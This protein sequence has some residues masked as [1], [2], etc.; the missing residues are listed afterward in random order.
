LANDYIEAARV[1]HEVTKHSYTSVRSSPHLLDWELKPLPYKIYPGAASVTLPRDLNL[2]GTPTLTALTTQIGTQSSAPVDITALTRIV[3][4]ADGLTRRK[5]VGGEDYHFRAAP[6]AGALYPIEIYVSAGEVEGLETG[7]YHFSPADLRMT[8][9]RRGDWREYL[10]RAAANRPSIANASAVIALS[11]I[12]WRS[13]WKYRA[14][15]YR[16]C[17]WDAGTMLANLLAAA[18]A[19]G[20]SA[21]VITAFEDPAL[22]N[23]LGIDGDREGMVALIALGRSEKGAAPSPDAPALTLETIPLSSNEVVYNDLVKMHRESRLVTTAE[24]ESVANAKLESSPQSSAPEL[25]R[26]DLIEPEEA[27]SL[28]QTILRRGSTRAFARDAI[29]AEELA[30]IMAASSEHPRADFPALTDT[31]LIVNAVTEME[32]GA[33]YYNRDERAFELLKLGDFRGEAGYLC[34]EQPLGMDCSALVVYMTDLERV[35]EALGNRGY[36]DAHLEAG[37][38]GG[39]AYLAAYALGRGATGLT[40]YDDDTTKFFE[41]HAKGKSPLLMVAIGVPRSKQPHL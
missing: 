12:Y 9:L 2:S 7:L 33:Y 6:S 1:F 17:Y 37:I 24:V 31:Y 35:L 30:T 41:P 14:R 15:A 26:F 28:G 23:L 29:T 27:A 10:A 4:C 19:E 13:A 11:A 40:F 39:R 18:A 36:G 8:G 25:L 22:E 32:P 21:E 38:H 3:F 16:Y 20:I 34:L 5:S